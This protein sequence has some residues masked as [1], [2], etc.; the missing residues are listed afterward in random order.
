MLD[1]EERWARRDWTCVTCGAR[2][3]HIVGYD[4]AQLSLGDLHHFQPWNFAKPD[5]ADSVDP[6]PCG[7]KPS[8]ENAKDVKA[9]GWR[10]RIQTKFTPEQHEEISK[11]FSE[12][13][14]RA[15]ANGLMEPIKA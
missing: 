10:R 2:L 1:V 15:N 12:V 7:C 6:W 4:P 11:V 3:A 8:V 5:N 14:R 13:F 9:R